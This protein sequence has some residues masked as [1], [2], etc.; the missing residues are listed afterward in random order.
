M[1]PTEKLF[2]TTAELA[3]RWSFSTRTLEGWRNDGI[4]VGYHRLNGRAI[5]YHID[6]I[7]RFERDWA[8][9]LQKS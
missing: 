8:H 4:G 1:A 6:D 5:R 7:E 2:Y 9:Y 3:E